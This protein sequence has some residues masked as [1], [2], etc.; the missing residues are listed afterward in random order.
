MS[1]TL[2]SKRHTVH[3]LGDAIEF[4]FAQGW[5]DG[6]PVVPPTTDRVGRM[7]E[8]AGLDPKQ[9]IGFAAHRAV[10]MRAEK[11]ATNADVAV[12]DAEV[13]A[14]VVGGGGGNADPRVR[15]HR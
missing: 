11:G 8:G 7:L 4:C 5:T 10:S 9:E 14:V 6:L 2:T 13:M 3:H 12:C 15:R 1:A